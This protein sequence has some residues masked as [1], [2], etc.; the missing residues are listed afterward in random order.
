[1]KSINLGDTVWTNN[2]WD[3]QA[4]I[5]TGKVGNKYRLAIPGVSNA[6]ILVDPSAVRSVANFGRSYRMTG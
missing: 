4:Y 1:M 3:V 2:D 5:C 6:S